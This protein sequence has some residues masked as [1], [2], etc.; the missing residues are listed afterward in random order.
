[1]IIDKCYANSIM[2]MAWSRTNVCI[3]YEVN[4]V[5]AARPTQQDNRKTDRK[6]DNRQKYDKDR[7][8]R[9]FVMTRHHIR[10]EIQPSVLI[11]K[12]R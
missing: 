4:F 5:Q 9:T 6:T 11:V 8:E 7:R 10:Q 2:A 1:M 3:H 12:R